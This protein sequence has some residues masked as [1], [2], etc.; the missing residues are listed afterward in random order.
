[1]PA[2]VAQEYCRPDRSFFPTPEFNDAT[3]PRKFTF[4]NWIT[5]YSDWFPLA[6][7]D[8]GL[9][10]N[11]SLV[12]GDRDEANGLNGLGVVGSFMEIDLV[13]VSRLDEVRTADLT[14]SRENLNP[15]AVTYGMSV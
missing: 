9:G 14:Q 10:F 11:F 12:R 5:N 4:H 3:L 8:S 2:H 15:Q 13:A 1:M 6:A 7:S